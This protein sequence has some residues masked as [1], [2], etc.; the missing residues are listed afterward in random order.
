MNL[1]GLFLPH[2]YCLL[3]DPYLLVAHIVSDVVTAL[4]YFVIPCCLWYLRRKKPDMIGKEILSLFSAFIFLCGWSHIMDMLTLYIGVYHLEAVVKMLTA[5]VSFITATVCIPSVKY[6]SK[7]K[8]PE[9]FS[10]TL[11]EQHISMLA[12]EQRNRT[13]KSAQGDY[14]HQSRLS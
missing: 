2:K 14:K 6:L 12:D 1:L 5:T 9:E 7:I 4:S 11:V 3:M 13:N 8:T 10:W